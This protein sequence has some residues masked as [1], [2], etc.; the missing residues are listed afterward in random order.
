M[1]FQTAHAHK[2]IFK[3]VSTD[4]SKDSPLVLGKTIIFAVASGEYTSIGMNGCGGK[5][6]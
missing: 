1:L 5:V 3:I 6:K 4:V 2:Y